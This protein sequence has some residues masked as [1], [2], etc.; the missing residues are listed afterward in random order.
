MSPRIHLVDAF[1]GPGLAGNPAGVCVTPEPMRDADMQVIAARVGFPETA[2][3]RTI[4]ALEAVYGL[5]WFTPL[6]EVP[7]CGHA[8]LAS[9]TVLFERHW[10]KARQI[11]FET[12]SGTLLARREEDGVALDF[13]ADPPVPRQAPKGI[14]EAL[15]A[16]D[17][18]EILY[19]EKTH[20]LLVRLRDAG[21]V[22]RLTPDFARLK[23]ADTSGELMG[24]IVTGPA[25]APY[26]F[27][28]RFF[29]PWVGVDEDPATGSSHTVLGP[30][31]AERLGKTQ[32]RGWQA[33]K[34]GG[35]LTVRVRND[36]RVDLVGKATIRPGS[37]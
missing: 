10:V 33:S 19:G 3:V 17:V 6:V 16:R 20:K 11:S 15:G 35:A 8:T 23:A 32:M 34:R 4:N 28:S 37:I 21:S 29:A 26:D 22:Q 24:V 18:E 13:P 27:A 25:S 31:W 7:L 30:Y 2:F 1:V 5:R 12:L 9:A 14:V 36:G